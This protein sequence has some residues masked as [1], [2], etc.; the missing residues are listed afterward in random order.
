MTTQLGGF[1]KN[2]SYKKH[3]SKSKRKYNGGGSGVAAFAASAPNDIGQ[4]NSNTQIVSSPSPFPT[5]GMPPVNT[6]AGGHRCS[7]RHKRHRR[8][9]NARAGRRSRKHKSRGKKYGM[10]LK[11]I[12][13]KS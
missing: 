3:K 6:M 2:S 11:S 10:S 4:A 12:F 8:T 13:G 9:R 1:T 5:G 7:M